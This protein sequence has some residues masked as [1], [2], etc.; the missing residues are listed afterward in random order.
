MGVGSLTEE[1][2]DLLFMWTTDL[3]G[4]VNMVDDLV[5]RLHSRGSSATRQQVRKGGDGIVLAPVS[6]TCKGQ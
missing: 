6:V 5:K 1:E 2:Q 4:S 3:Q